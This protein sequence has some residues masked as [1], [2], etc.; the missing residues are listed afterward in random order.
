M[1]IGGEGRRA[2]DS[3]L[4]MSL[5]DARRQRLP[6]HA[7]VAIAE[8]LRARF[9]ELEETA[10]TRIYGVSRP[11]G[12]LDLDY[13]AG[14]RAAVSAALAYGIEVV[15]SGERHAPP[16]PL[17][18]LSQARLAARR[19]IELEIVVRRCLVGYTLLG[20]FVAQEAARGD[21]LDA[22]DVQ[23]LFRDQTAFIDRLL[24]SVSEEY[25]R[26]A[27]G[28]GRSHGER[29]AERVRGLLVGDLLDTSEFP[30]EFDAWHIGTVASG[31]RADKAL[32]PLAKRLNCQILLASGGQAETWAWFG[33]RR[34]IA[35]NEFE[36]KVAGEWPDGIS[37][38]I[39]E[40][41]YG[42]S[43]W[44]HTHRQ[45]R[46]ALTLLID[47]QGGIFRYADHALTVS[48]SQDDLLVASLFDMYVTPLTDAP[49]G[50]ALLDTLR[51]YYFVAQRNV[52][53]TATV[54]DISRKTVER[55]LATV[56]KRLGRQLHAC[57]AELEGVLRLHEWG[58]P[59]ESRWSQI[60]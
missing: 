12:A 54:L 24:S 17:V 40:P 42:L 39:G 34:R 21:P 60:G 59:E 7:R 10:L 52:S 47:G 33:S 20:D 8:R 30:Y 13:E 2:S 53:S 4:R 6:G 49:D 5:Q 25:K 1:L 23:R 32:R 46:A 28:R 19:G 18:L 22:R 3:T 38:A 26:E 31:P 36:G 48:M 9:P 51:A 44:R 50:K 41:G 11:S 37:L 14:L 15:E 55:R 56:E 27:R 57:S 45:A 58:L 43:G 16:L 29:F 35:S